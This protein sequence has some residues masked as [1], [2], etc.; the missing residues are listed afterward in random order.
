M[1]LVFLALLTG[2]SCA[3]APAALQAALRQEADPGALWQLA[4]LAGAE[5]VEILTARSRDVQGQEALVVPVALGLSR[6][7][8]A[9]G[10]LRRV[11]P[12]TREAT[13]GR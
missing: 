10:A 8:E 13:L 2:A 1:T 11:P 9:L 6:R 12:N 4:P 5:G 3:D 7:A